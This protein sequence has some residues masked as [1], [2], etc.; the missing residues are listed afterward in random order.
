MGAIGAAVAG[1]A[2]SGGISA[3][4]AKKGGGAS[5][6]STEQTQ[7]SAP[8]GPQQPLIQNAYTDARGIYDQRNAQGPYTGEFTAGNVQGQTDTA[9]NALTWTGGTGNALAGQT[10]GTAGTLQGAAP[11]YVN[12]ATNM[13][14][15]G[16][17]GPDQGLFNTLRGYGTGAMQ[18]Q[19]A[20]PGLSHALNQSAIQGANALGQFQ[21]TLS[22]ASQQGLSD[23]T[24]RI[25]ADASAYANNPGVQAALNSTN[26]QI[27]QT[28]HEQTVPGLNRQAAQG[29]VLNSS[30]AGMAE[31]MANEGAGI[32]KGNADASI[33]N[34]AYNSGLST[35]ANTYSTGLNSA[36]NGSM[37]GYN[38]LANMANAQANQQIGQ[39]QF[40]TNAMLGAA[41]T[42]LN[43][44]LGYQTADAGAR[45]N[46]NGQLGTA[47]GLGVNAATAAGNQAQTNF[48]TGAAAGGLLQQGN[49]LADNNAL[50]QWNMNNTYGQNVLNDYWNIISKPMGSSAQGSTQNTLPSNLMGNVVGGGLAGYGLYKNAAG[51][52]GSGGIDQGLGGIFGGN[53]GW[54]AGNQNGAGAAADLAAQYQPTGSYGPGFG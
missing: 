30:R 31:S 11:G 50:Q 27:D 44:G 5:G 40:N 17:A 48:G 54:Y 15:N 51:Q 24:Q 20:S 37:F 9:N 4:T 36:I 42:G 1:A 53:T 38:D 18:T 39:N 35:A 49:Q 29:G 25:A 33:L 19:G 34:N 26:A 16:I 28:L 13:A 21:N 52:G 45:L 6:G 3:L 2:V 14:A 12:N 23:P 8:W 41:G 47:A 7:S 32:A 10:A 43:S 46:A 22:T